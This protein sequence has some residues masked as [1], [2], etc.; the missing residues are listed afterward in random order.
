MPTYRECTVDI[1]WHNYQEFAEWCQWQK[2]F[3]KGAALDKDLLFP[4]NK[5]YSPETC[6][7]LPRELNTVI[8]I[9]DTANGNLPGVY[10]DGYS[11]RVC[12]TGVDGSKLSKRF[13]DE[14][15]AFHWYCEAKDKRVVA[16]AQKYYDIL[17][18]RAIHALENFNTISRWAP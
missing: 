13:F 1:Q 4:S 5:K 14:K 3:T 17:D 8:Q 18:E 12:T 10:N 2:G 9:G 15:E 16:V 6:C 7:F 11:F